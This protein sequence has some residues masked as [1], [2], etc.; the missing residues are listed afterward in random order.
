[1]IFINDLLELKDR[2]LY[3]E[4]NGKKIPMSL[5]FYIAN[6]IFF[7]NVDMHKDTKLNTLEDLRNC[8]EIEAQDSCWCED[9]Y[10]APMNRIGSCEIRFSRNF[11]EDI[12]DDSLLFEDCY[13]IITME[14]TMDDIIIRLK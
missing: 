14:T 2:N 13:T 8:L 3:L 11:F 9:I 7:F 6:D 5:Q 1:M 10:Q 12:A 4:I